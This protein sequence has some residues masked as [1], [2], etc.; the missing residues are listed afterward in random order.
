M[1]VAVVH[2]R[3]QT[4]IPEL[5]FVSLPCCVFDKTYQCL[6]RH[7]CKNTLIHEPLYTENTKKS[8]ASGC[9]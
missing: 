4:V 5:V 1:H 3:S 2:S 9:T 6:Q 7:N 8:A